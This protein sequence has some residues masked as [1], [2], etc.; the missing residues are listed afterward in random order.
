MCLAVDSFTQITRA[1][2]ARPLTAIDRPYKR[3]KSQR[4]SNRRSRSAISV[5]RSRPTRHQ[6]TESPH[7]SRDLSSSHGQLGHATRVMS[8]G[9]FFFVF[10]YFIGQNLSTDFG[11]LLQPYLM[12]N[13]GIIALF[14]EKAGKSNTWTHR[15][16]RTGCKRRQFSA[17][18]PVDKS[19]SK[20]LRQ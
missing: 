8:Q 18:Q 13:N 7:Y 5:L 17:S 1:D 20:Q 3:R 4:K 6:R 14:A 2:N 10:M 9:L 11:S 15:D 12:D 19:A 16:R